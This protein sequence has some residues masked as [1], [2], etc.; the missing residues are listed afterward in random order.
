MSH[1][2]RGFKSLATHRIADMGEPYI[3][4]RKGK[5]HGKQNVQDH[6]G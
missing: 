2:R 4:F 3:D 1:D 5:Q 6:T